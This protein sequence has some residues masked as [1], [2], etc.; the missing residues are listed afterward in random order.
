MCVCVCVCVCVSEEA[1]AIGSFSHL[2]LK[3]IFAH[4]RHSTVKFSHKTIHTTTSILN[5]IGKKYE[6]HAITVSI[7]STLAINIP[8]L[9][10]LCHQCQGQT[11]NSMSIVMHSVN[12]ITFGRECHSCDNINSVGVGNSLFRH[13]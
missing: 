10:S 3:L 1:N 13:V 12:L 7:I 4:R 6:K 11:N 9:G 5:T 8:V 2:C